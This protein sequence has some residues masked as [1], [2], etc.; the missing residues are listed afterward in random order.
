MY[1]CQASYLS[2]AP[3]GSGAVVWTLS[4]FSPISSLLFQDSIMNLAS[5]SR[6]G[7]NFDKKDEVYPPVVHPRWFTPCVFLLFLLFI[8]FRCLFFVLEQSNTCRSYLFTRR[9]NAIQV[10]DH[11]YSQCSETYPG[12]RYDIGA[13]YERTST[14]ATTWR[15]LK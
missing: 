3:P 12:Q 10:W 4:P 7:G 8:S 6:V 1:E 11:F 13:L 9:M 2:L 14:I 5:L 15:S